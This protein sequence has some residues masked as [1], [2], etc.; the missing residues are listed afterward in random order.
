MNQQL[1][2]QIDLQKLYKSLRKLSQEEYMDYIHDGIAAALA[3]KGEFQSIAHV[4]S[5]IFVGAKNSMISRY[6]KNAEANKDK[7]KIAYESMYNNAYRH[8][9]TQFQAD[10]DKDAI[11]AFLLPIDGATGRPRQACFADIFLRRYSLPGYNEIPKLAEEIGVTEE[12]VTNSLKQ[13]R[14]KIAHLYPL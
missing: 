1:I 9:S 11:A 10:N 5:F 7:Y 8:S 6:K 4:E 2:A 3:Y 12:Y 13:I 14:R